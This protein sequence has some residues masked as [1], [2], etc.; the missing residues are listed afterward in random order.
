MLRA[1]QSQTSNCPWVVP[2]Y[3]KVRIVGIGPSNLQRQRN[4]TIPDIKGIHKSTRF[5]LGFHAGS[6]LSPLGVQLIPSTP[7]SEAFFLGTN[8]GAMNQNQG[9]QMFTVPSCT[10][11]RH[12][13]PA[14][15]SIDV[16][17]KNQGHLEGTRKPF[18]D[19][20]ES[21]FLWLNLYV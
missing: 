20:R 11:D 17:L 14:D 21:M 18:S 6:S 10:I 5:K 19:V 7:K 13:P 3:P 4:S 12:T 15:A 2:S 1:A 8:W 16:F 9:L